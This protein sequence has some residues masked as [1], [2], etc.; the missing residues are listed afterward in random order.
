[1]KNKKILLAILAF[2]LVLGMTV[3][4]CSNGSTGG[5]GGNGGTG[6]TGGTDGKGNEKS[7]S[8]YYLDDDS[9]VYWDNNK[10]GHLTLKYP[11]V[12]IGEWDYV[13]TNA[14]TVFD[15]SIYVAGYYNTSKAMIPNYV[16][17]YW[18]D[19]IPKNLNV[20][21]ID[22]LDHSYAADIVVVGDTVYVA[23]Y[24]V[25]KNNF[26][27]LCY[28]KNGVRT[29]FELNS[30]SVGNSYKCYLAVDGNTVAVV[31]DN[32]NYYWKDGIKT[33]LETS[34]SIFSIDSIALDGTDVYITGT[35]FDYDHADDVD[36]VST[37][38][39]KNGKINEL[40]IL[41][42]SS[43][44]LIKA[45]IITD[46]MFYAAGTVHMD[47]GTDPMWADVR[48]CYW[49]NWLPQPL[50]HL[51]DSIY[52]GYSNAIAIDNS[53][54][55]ITGC[56]MKDRD[57]RYPVFVYWKNGVPNVL[58]S[59]KYQLGQIWDVCMVIK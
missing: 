55:Y 20:S 45:I 27:S 21:D 39:W 59:I 33:F 44:N 24:Y 13:R 35:L 52:V 9:V 22:N 16:A 40:T 34:S 43:I 17:C 46:G 56:Y 38:Y 11:A 10:S 57:T 48:T 7:V 58:G 4:G 3:I 12:D 25:T 31:S 51:P 2:T 30:G 8:I 19:G 47:G 53:D 29:D 23:G 5:G 54:V 14:I 1:M 32:C 50:R 49:E 18:K 36:A 37:H 26:F 15:D 28:W 42:S 6:S 41:P